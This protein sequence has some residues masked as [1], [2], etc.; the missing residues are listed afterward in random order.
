M[1]VRFRHT[2]NWNP[3][4]Q[5]SHLLIELIGYVIHKYNENWIHT[6]HSTLERE[7]AKNVAVEFRAFALQK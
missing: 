6:R 2:D 1:V 7:T 5:L 3:R 4:I